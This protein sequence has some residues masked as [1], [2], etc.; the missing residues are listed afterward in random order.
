MHTIFFVATCRVARLGYLSPVGLL[1][2]M[3]LKFLIGI[4]RLFELLTNA[5]WRFWL[6]IGGLRNNHFSKKI[7]SYFSKNVENLQYILL[8][9]DDD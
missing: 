6:A 4:L 9:T 7:V 3:R 5:F 2:I 1:L 8:E